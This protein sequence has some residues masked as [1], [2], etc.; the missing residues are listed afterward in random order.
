MPENGFTSEPVRPRIEL[1]AGLTWEAV[2]A[3]SPE[4]P[5]FGKESQWPTKGMLKIMGGIRQ[6]VEIKTDLL[7]YCDSLPGSDELLQLINHYNNRFYNKDDGDPE[8][9]I[10]TFINWLVSGGKDLQKID[11]ELEKEPR[12]IKFQQDLKDPLGRFAVRQEFL[13]Q[14]LSQLDPQKQVI[15]AGD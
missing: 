14:L 6:G 2:A 3:G 1:P 15:N 10:E 9:T 12:V 4:A 8:G 13:K 7:R 11:E 5:V